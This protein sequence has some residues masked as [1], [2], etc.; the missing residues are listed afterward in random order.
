MRRILLFMLLFILSLPD[1][2]GQSDE[3]IQVAAQKAVRAY[4]LNGI[5]SSVQ[6]GTVTLTGF[7]EL[8]RDR[9]LALETVKRIYGVKT[10]NDQIEVPGPRIPDAQLKAQI[11]QIIKDRIHKLGGFGYGSMKANV[12]EGVVTLSGAAAPELT[13]PA[14]NA[15][16]GTLGVRNLIDNVV[17]VSHY[18]FAPFGISGAPRMNTTRPQ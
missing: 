8:C 14:I 10:I 5:Q 12:K 1:A 11:N 2:F 18:D 9:L 17:R 13:T 16:A 4:S 7:V 3:E 15:I 6:N